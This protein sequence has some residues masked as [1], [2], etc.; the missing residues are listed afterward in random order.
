MYKAIAV[1]TRI[2]MDTAPRRLMMNRRIKQMK[3]KQMKI[4]EI[5]Q[6]IKQLAQSQGFYGRLD[7]SLSE[8]QEEYIDRYEQVAAEL[9][10]QNFKDAVDLILYLGG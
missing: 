10:S 7:R 8:L 5:R 9:E 4:N 1:H 2:V 6:T 3:I